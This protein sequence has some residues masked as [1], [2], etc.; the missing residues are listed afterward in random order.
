LS[1]GLLEGL[2]PVGGSELEDAALG[3]TREQTQ[4]V[5]HVA[6]RLDAVEPS[7]GEQRDETGIGD[8][9][10]ITADEKPVSAPEDR[11]AQ[12]QFGNIVVHGQTPVVEEAPQRDPLIVR[13][14]KTGR[15]RRF[16]QNQWRFGVAPLEELVDDGPRF[17]ASDL[18]FLLARRVRDGPL[19]P[20]QRT[21]MRERDLGALRV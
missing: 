4:Q 15:H 5:A 6:E 11:P 3:P 19:D 17:R 1:F 10:I 18:L 8:A 7:T 21:D 2:F 14:R 9:A 20:K 13:I 12:V 16:V